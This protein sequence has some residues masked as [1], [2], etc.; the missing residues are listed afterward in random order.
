MTQ[1]EFENLIDLMV[2]V[3]VTACRVNRRR[4]GDARI[5][6]ATLRPMQD[7]SFAAVEELVLKI[8]ANE[9]SI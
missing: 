6:A 4:A 9:V 8:A 5:P 2:E 3:G 1:T 7:L